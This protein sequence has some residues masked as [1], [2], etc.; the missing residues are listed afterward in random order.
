MERCLSWDPRV[1]TSGMCDVGR[2][3][4]RASLPEPYGGV[5]PGQQGAD[6]MVRGV[7]AGW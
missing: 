2:I 7:E 5:P 4:W 1:V 6:G 3:T